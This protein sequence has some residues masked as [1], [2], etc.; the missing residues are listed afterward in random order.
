MH[1]PFCLHVKTSGRDGGNK[2]WDGGDGRSGCTEMKGQNVCA[3][4]CTLSVLY[5]LNSFPF[6]QPAATKLN[7]A[8]LLSVNDI[9]DHRQLG[10]LAD[11][12]IYFFF[13]CER[14]CI[15]KEKKKKR[16]RSNDLKNCERQKQRWKVTFMSHKRSARAAWGGRNHLHIC[17]RVIFIFCGWLFVLVAEAC[18]PAAVICF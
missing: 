10:W 8:S 11:F 17:L 16:R 2:G 13:W 9:G 1:V 7:S 15:G 6:L 12:Y 4:M 18:E 14:I 3:V 5:I